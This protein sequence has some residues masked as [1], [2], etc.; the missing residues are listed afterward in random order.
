MQ[1]MARKEK[2]TD[3]DEELKSGFKQFDK[4]QDGQI[5]IE[6]L[7]A[8]MEELGE[9]LSEEE[10]QEMINV[11]SMEGDGKVNFEDRFDVLLSVITVAPLYHLYGSI[12]TA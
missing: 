5:T 2:N 6:D 11:A 10:L 7:R 8:L 12:V 3:T 1:L 9:A 4:N